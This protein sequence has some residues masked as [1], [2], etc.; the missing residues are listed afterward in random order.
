[1]TF[2]FAFLFFFMPADVSAKDVPE[3][4]W[5]F[6]TIESDERNNYFKGK[7]YGE[8]QEK[9]LENAE[10]DARNQALN[11][12][13]VSVQSETTVIQRNDRTDLHD[14]SKT[15]SNAVLRKFKRIKTPYCRKDEDEFVCYVQY[16]YPLKELQKERKRLS[17]ERSGK[18]FSE[19][20]EIVN[21]PRN[22]TLTVDTG[23]V[24]ADLYV[25]GEKT[26]KTPCK[27]V[28]VLTPEQN[29]KIKIDSKAHE[30]YE[31]EVIVFKNMVNPLN[32]VLKPAYAS[33]K[34]EI[35]PDPDGAVLKM[36][37][38]KIK[39]GEKQIVQAGTD[40]R[41]EA[42]HPQYEKF[43]QPFTFSR[44]EKKTVKIPL[45]EKEADLYL[46]VSNPDYKVAV[47]GE[48]DASTDRERHFR[49]PSG[50]HEITVYMNKSKIAS[51]TVTLKPADKLPL[52]ISEEFLKSR[53]KKQEKINLLPAVFIPYKST[54]TI[55]GKFNR[56]KLLNMLNDID[57]SYLVPRLSY[58]TRSGSVRFTVTVEI[59]PK[60]YRE[61]FVEPLKKSISEASYSSSK[62]K[63]TD[64]ALRC[65]NVE[66]QPHQFCG[67]EPVSVPT[68]AFIR[69]DNPVSNLFSQSAPF[70]SV[71]DIPDWMA[72][73]DDIPVKKLEVYF[74][75]FD[76]NK[77]NLA[78]F[79]FPFTLIPFQ[80]VG[81]MYVFSP[82]MTD[83]KRRC[84]EKKT[85][86]DS[87]EFVCG[88]TV[89]QAETGKVRIDLNSVSDIYISIGAAK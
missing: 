36:N 72:D 24:V 33:V 42:E 44:G 30:I 89:F 41:I 1:M 68:T 54:G 60:K 57:F 13:G 7:G 87:A 80:I 14:S 63:K 29:H 40:V 67:V 38:R 77:N 53:R 58:D 32:P 8:N 74:A 69:T 70:L 12:L 10:K 62:A 55:S 18:R 20:N 79:S 17:Q 76:G 61:A 19:M 47:D 28:G 39:S 78:A 45:Q 11:Y 75:L 15:F 27:L 49:L 26:C 84:L 16:S 88:T 9:A 66:G 52:E 56:Q 21:D 48:V 86:G 59:D 22:G 50:E 64:L 83:R 46:T 73:Y 51:E 35:E 85:F 43:R 37:G 5:I 65:M 25:D 3:P 34:F 31:S 82:V 23:N 81:N 2:L 4:E 71:A 6:Q